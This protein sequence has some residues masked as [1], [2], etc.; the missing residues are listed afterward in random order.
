MVDYVD[1]KMDLHVLNE[2]SYVFD[3]VTSTSI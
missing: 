1:I 2:H 3:R